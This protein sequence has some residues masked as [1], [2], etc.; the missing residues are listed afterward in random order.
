MDTLTK[1]IIEK[2]KL[3]ISLEILKNSPYKEIYRSITKARTIGMILE[4]CMKLPEEE[5]EKLKD[6]LDNNIKTALTPGVY[7]KVKK[8]KHI[9]NTMSF[10]FKRDKK[11]SRL[12]TIEG[13]RKRKTNYE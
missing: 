8:E 3:Q 13:I 12:V 2:L 9:P 1:D 7:I 5:I 6:K 11:H 4:A 10:N